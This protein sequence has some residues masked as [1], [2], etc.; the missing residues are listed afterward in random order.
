MAGIRFAHPFFGP[1]TWEGLVA[2]GMLQRTGYGVF[3][4]T[5]SYFGARAGV[6]IATALGP[7][8]IEYGAND[9]GRGRMF[10]RFGEW[11]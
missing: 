1:V 10:F 4:N 7:F 2:G 11:F 8:I 6:G 9:R 5:T 3:S